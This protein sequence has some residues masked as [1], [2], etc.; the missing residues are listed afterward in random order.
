VVNITDLYKV[1]Y[2]TLLCHHTGGLFKGES[3]RYDEKMWFEVFR[4]DLKHVVDTVE[5]SVL[6]TA[7]TS[8]ESQ[9]VDTPRRELW[10]KP[11]SWLGQIR[12]HHRDETWSASLW[13]TFFVSCVGVY[14]QVLT[15]LPF[16]VCGWRKFQIDPWGTTSTLLQ[17]TRVSRRNTTGQLISLLTSFAQHTKWKHNRWLGAEVS[18]V[19][20]WTWPDT[21]QMCRVRCLW[22]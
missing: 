16:W 1:I 8:L 20:T 15:E 19:G 3:L 14:I 12:P 6:H 21:F 2:Y 13:Q 22:C 4:C 9:G 10:I 7:M 17:S 18:D 11:M 5:D